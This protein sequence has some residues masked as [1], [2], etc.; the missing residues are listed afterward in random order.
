MRC[1]K[2]QHENPDDSTFCG[3]CATRLGAEAQRSPTI[4]LEATAEELPL[5]KTL[6][7]R[8]RVIS[9]L[10][11][12]GMGKVYRAEDTSLSRHVA[13]K[14]LPAEFA[15]DPERL[16]RFER[17][18]R[19]LAALNHP[20]IASIHGI[21]GSEGKR[22]LVLELAE[23]ETL[24]DRLDKGPLPVEEALE[25]CR[26]IAEGLEAAHEKG[27]VHRD[28]KPGNVMITPDGKIKILDFGLAKA[29]RGETT[30]VDIEKSPTITA[31]MTEPGVILGTA[32]YMSPEQA[33]GRPADRRADVWAL[34]CILY[35]CL[36]G[37][38]AFEGDTISDTL[39]QVLKG[40]PDWAALPAATPGTVSALLRRCL[41]KNPRNRLHDIADARIEIDEAGSPAAEGG[42]NVEKSAWGR[43]LA[44]GAVLF[45]AGFLIR[46]LIWE[47]SRPASSPGPAASIVKL[48]PGYT[49]D[50][51]R[52]ILEYG[53][54]S[55]TAVVI[56]GDGRF[57]VYCA[58]D[59]TVTDAKPRLFMRPIEE[60]EAK[61]IPGTEGGIAPF[62][63]PDD[64]W[65]G[66]WADGRLKKA[67]IEG[68]IAQDLGE[69][70]MSR[71]CWGDQDRIV[72]EDTISQGLSMVAASG[73]DPVVLT[74]PD[75]AQDEGDHRLP[76]CL[77]D[78]RGILFTVARPSMGS[79]LDL[80]PRV[81]LFD[82]RTGARKF[83][84]DDASDARYVR[85]GH[86][87][88]LRRGVLWAVPFDL[89]QMETSGPETPVRSGVIQALVPTSRN[90]MAG[91]YSVSRAGHLVFAPGGVPPAW[92]NSLAWVDREGNDEPV[93]PRAE[94]HYIPR[95]SPDGTKIVFQ[96]LYAS[97]QVWVYDVQRD[98][99][100]PLVSEGASGRPIWTPDG[101]KIIYR[102]VLPDR[103]EG[104]YVISAE[105]IEAKEE[106]L[107]APPPGHSY[108]PSS[109]S[110][111]GKRLALVG[112][113]A[114]QS[115]DIYIYQIESRSLA[116]FRVTPDDE[117]YPSFSPDGRWILYTSD[118]EGRDDVYVSPADG[119]GGF[120]MVSLDGGKEPGWARNGGQVFYRTYIDT[121]AA[122]VSRMW[123]VEVRPGTAFSAGRP[124]LLFEGQKYG[125]SDTVS[126][127]DISQDDRRFLMV[128]RD[129]R[130]LRPV[131]ELVLV[132]NWFEEIRRLGPKGS[133]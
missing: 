85:T 50:G 51:Y 112:Y 106:M 81:A 13:I 6:A 28:L 82:S 70:A 88:F 99:S 114:E 65:V 46:P 90:T 130:P 120:V 55:M 52:D 128:R 60:L 92:V 84:I 61:P 35:E 79:V 30:G 107:F 27:I 29:Y 67:P 9:Q 121:P 93:G 3:K 69:A 109:V 75:S 100:Y 103:S 115:G 17:E 43:V 131:T 94:R 7:G 59:D 54:P 53:W 132:Q 12:G 5:G 125:V 71:A 20:N 86:V 33:R 22:F 77:P 87:V 122:N 127:W 62:L 10:G 83:L 37:K 2:C 116:P 25:T 129:D 74:T 64:R 42:A 56:S 118:R 23:G 8:Y 38:R 91:Q 102:K 80:K 45:I 110:P 41:Q 26:Q 95:L 48:E 24:R 15:R 39:A 78:G 44:A 96:T 123:A 14:V 97:E 32:A 98:M 101:T 18:A 21:E 124:R 49:L 108:I 111:D 36:A 63:S 47:T 34:G 68:G 16:A 126:C 31:H 66:F 57:I 89:R 19:L 4:T 104:I 113:E 133:K 1:P 119:S 11:Q 72:F 73:G 58:V 105:G 40:E 76:S 117:N